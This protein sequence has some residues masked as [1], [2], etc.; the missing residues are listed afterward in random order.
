M[1][2]VLTIFIALITIKTA[3]SQEPAGISVKTN[4]LNL[5][6]KRPSFSIEK[7]F[8]QKYGLEVSYSSGE[9]NWG[10][11]YKYD[12]FLLRG[13]MYANK[14]ESKEV[15]PFFGIYAGNLNKTIISNNAYVHPTGFLSFGNNRNFKANSI[16]SGINLGFLYLP[17]KRFL[18]E[19]TTGIGYGKYFNMK[20]FEGRD[21]P[22]GYLDF[23]LWLSVGYRF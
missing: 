20:T 15:T 11:E 21:A 6:A 9:L 10:R 3:S 19:T 7:T 12:G 8:A 14:I 4:L 13:K 1:K 5:V 23:Q 18:L 22:K 2:Y 17:S 16:R